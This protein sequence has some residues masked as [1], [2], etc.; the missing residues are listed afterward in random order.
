M[1]FVARSLAFDRERTSAD[2][3]ADERRAPGFRQ[4]TEKNVTNYKILNPRTPL[5]KF[6]F[7]GIRQ[8]YD[9]YLKP[10][11]KN[12]TFYDFRYI[13]ISNLLQPYIIPYYRVPVGGGPDPKQR[14]LVLPTALLPQ[15]W[16]TR[17]TGCLSHFLV[18]NLCLTVTPS[19]P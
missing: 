17:N 16:S 11:L 1:A 4:N 6:K 5:K 18:L 15:N 19:L 10:P 13:N 3:R 14:P 12:V 9:S 7:N 2:S 8:R